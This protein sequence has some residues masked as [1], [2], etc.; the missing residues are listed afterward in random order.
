MKI[1][2]NKLKVAVLMGGIGQERDI[3]IQSGRCVAEALEQAGLNVVTADIQPDNMDVLEDNSIDVFFIA[4]H[5]KFGEDGRLQQILEDKSLLY[6]GSGPA[7]SSLA[8]DKM[9]SKKLFT[10]AG[11]A[12][13]AAIE[14]NADT[15]IRKLEKQLP[16]FG[17][18]FVIK[19]IRQGSSIG[20]SIVSDRHKAI[21]AAQE[22]LKRFGDCMIEK[23]VPGREVTVGILCGQALPIIEIRT[24]TGFYNYQA[25]YLDQRTEFLFDTIDDVS[26]V[27]NIESAALD[28][29]NA[30]G[31]RHFA[32][33]DFI[34]GSDRIPY[35]L[36]VN[37]IPGFTSHSLLPKAAAK[38]GLSMSDL[39]AKI[40]EAALT[41]NCSKALKASDKTS[42]RAKRSNLYRA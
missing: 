3:S 11:V 29:F 25:K 32:R 17:D 4:M 10:Q 39:C 28:C 26:I 20:V 22:T 19:P 31:C 6:T 14:L 24:Q 23:F 15:D 42:L 30:L 12:A 40:V 33:V 2:N 27:K 18:K 37:T 13:A 16:E 7:A 36:E 1:E 5:G 41:K 38:V 34:L 9:A 21:A 8:F 35:A